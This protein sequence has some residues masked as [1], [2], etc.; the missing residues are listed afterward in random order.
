MGLYEEIAT[1]RPPTSKERKRLV[2]EQH[3]K[4]VLSSAD[5]AQSYVRLLKQVG[6]KTTVKMDPTVK[7]TLC[8]GCDT[9]LIP[10]VSA[11]TR[12]KPSSMHGNTIH[13]T[14]LRCKHTRRIPAPPEPDGADPLATEVDSMDVDES[15]ADTVRRK[16]SRRRRGAKPH[17]RPFFERDDHVVFRG[18]VQVRPIVQ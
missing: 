11:T 15:D 10:G 17:P 2:R 3:R 12:V 4:R 18:N 16:R 1:C 7:R 9:V 13:T 14:C 5:V 6:Q 8:Q